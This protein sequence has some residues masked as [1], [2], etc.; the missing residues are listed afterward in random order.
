M[1]ILDLFDTKKEVALSLAGLTIG[2]L[3]SLTLIDFGTVAA[4]IKD[5]VALPT[6][7]HFFATST[8]TAFLGYL[9][10]KN[11]KPKEESS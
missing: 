7:M 5:A 4:G 8:G 9:L 10:G 6:E 1:G 2:G 3:V 11:Q